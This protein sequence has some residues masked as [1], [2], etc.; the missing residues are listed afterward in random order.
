[1][2][3]RQRRG[4][5]GTLIRLLFTLLA[6]LCS[7]PLVV[8]DE[9]S[10]ESWQV[11]WS[12]RPRQAPSPAFK[13][14]LCT[15]KK[16]EATEPIRYDFAFFPVVADGRVVFASSSEH[17]VYCL[18]A[19]TGRQQW[20]FFADGPVRI[21][22][23]IA[24]GRVY[25]GSDDGFAYCLGLAGG[26]PV[27]KVR[28]APDARRA[29]GNGQIIS[30]WPVRTRVAVEDGVAYFGAG[31]L[32]PLGTYLCA[33]EAMSGEQ[34]FRREI[35]YSLHGGILVEDERLLVATG[36]TAP[37]EFRRDD[38]SPLVANPNPRRAS[39][40]SFLD[41]AA[42]LVYWG[43]CEAGL[44]HVRVSDQA[45]PE[46]PA[47]L[48]NAV[49]TGRVVGIRGA[50]LAAA[51][52]RIYLARDRSLLAFDREPFLRIVKGFGFG[53]P[54]YA[55][56]NP[57]TK[58]GW[59][60]AAAGQALTEDARLFGELQTAILWKCEL[61]QPGHSL[62]VRGEWLFCGGMNRVSICDARTGQR[63]AEVAVE[64]DAIGLTDSE[65]GLCVATDQGCVYR[66]D[67]RPPP[68]TVTEHRPGPRIVSSSSHQAEAAALLEACGTDQGFCLVLGIDLLP[69]AREIAEQSRM[70]VVIV[71]ADEAAVRD[72][73]EKLAAAGVYGSRIAV[74][75]TA[76]GL[77]SYP[78]YFANLIVAGPRSSFTPA[79]MQHVLRPYGGT[80]VYLGE[81]A[82]RQ[83]LHGLGEWT[84]RTSPHG[85]PWSFVRRQALADAGQWSQMYADPAGT[86]SSGDRLTGPDLSLQWF[87]PPGAEDVV[88]RHSVAMPPL[89]K[90]GR[91]FVAG[92]YDT[93]QAV[94]A[95]NGAKL[96]KVEVPEATRMMLSH[97]AGFM[98][99][100]DDSLF[101]AADAECW[102]LDAANGK[103][104]HRFRGPRSDDDWGYVGVIEGLLL[105]TNQSPAAD[106]YSSGRTRPGYGFQVSAKN[107]LSRPAVSRNLFAYRIADYQPP[108]DTRPGSSISSQ[109]ERSSDSSPWVSG[110]TAWEYDRGSVIVNSSIAIGDGRIFFIESRNPAV[111]QDE[112]GTA[113]L[114]DFFQR[115]AR[116]VALDLAAG[117]E[118]WAVPLGRLSERAEDRHEHIVYASFADGILL[119][120]RTGHVDQVLAYKL[121][122]RDA[123]TGELKWIQ[124]VPSKHRVYAPLSYGKNGQQSHPC[125]I[126]GRIYLLS[127]IT[128]ALL[129]FDLQTGTMQRDPDLFDF[130]IHSK[131]CAVPTGSASG[132]FFRRDSCQMYDLPTGRTV[133]LTGVT[134]PSCWMSI[135][136]AGGLILMPEASAG[137]TCGFALQTSVVLRARR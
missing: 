121:E 45:V 47:G 34:V 60:V 76:G 70:H 90:N 13:G 49:A 39:G 80:L 92:L 111:V 61:D 132:L 14:G 100:G 5:M 94:D 21:R 37:A 44:L 129:S 51:G 101:V 65:D 81:V 4:I 93:V 12:F 84:S 127:H 112:S 18:D 106:D 59:G 20:R 126:D 87:G 78:E 113:S 74:H 120:T 130:W 117:T 124:I 77:S 110:P 89:F 15:W 86:L 25:F 35:P 58:Q 26:E 103:T 9:A 79:E 91:L 46:M 52:D 115:D 28:A 116:L 31:L 66:L 133:D 123:G 82:E 53:L 29:I 125:I 69:L 24:Q 99:A 27:W 3:Q 16:T 98:A 10:G 22:P 118:A 68:A 88:E 102:M 54:A 36:R 56:G 95:Y 7:S 109:S 71:D 73:R 75:G 85:T 42:G 57:W 8:A 33:V 104:L 19:L 107:L 97:Q 50:S 67:C 11:A 30:A 62:A 6:L 134:R 114:A 43:P 136:P 128:E 41:R 131:T 63:R 105:G 119:T 96:W 1:M 40:S 32:P 55:K 83:D 17:A 135:I 2:K 64:G 23:T 137:C 108:H 122:A 38:G 72:A 48:S